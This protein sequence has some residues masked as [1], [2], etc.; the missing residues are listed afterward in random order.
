VALKRILGVKPTFVR[1]PY[2][3]YSA[4]IPNDP[5]HHAP[6]GS[7]NNITLTVAGRRNQHREFTTAE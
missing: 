6:E 3:K 5:D 1:P 2:G 7:Y 4:A